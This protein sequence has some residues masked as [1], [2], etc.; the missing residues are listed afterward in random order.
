MVFTDQQRLDT[1]SAWINHFKTNTPGMDLFVQR[2]VRFSNAFCTAPI[3]SPS[4]STLLTG[5][6]PT[7]AGVP[8]NLG[9]PGGPLD[10]AKG[11]L[12]NRMQALGYETVYHGKWHREWIQWGDV[13]SPIRMVRSAHWKYVHYIGIGEELYSVDDDPGEITNRADD[14]ECAVVLEQHRVLLK[15]HCEENNDN[16]YNLI[17]SDPVQPV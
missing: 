5:L 3:C 1:I 17:P 8:G 16:F 9:Q 2:G 7:A 10:E 6:F 4:R 12:G 13:I 14:P 11:T 15:K